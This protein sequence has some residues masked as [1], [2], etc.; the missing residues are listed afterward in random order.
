MQTGEV[1]ASRYVVH[2][3][4]E[5]YVF[6]SI[7][8]VVALTLNRAQLKKTNAF[9]TYWEIILVQEILSCFVLYLTCLNYFLRVFY[10]WK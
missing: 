6:P 10:T 9:W 3:D 5:L 8:I 7:W 2:V 4:T 1:E